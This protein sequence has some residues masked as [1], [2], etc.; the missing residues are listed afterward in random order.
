MVLA[1]ACSLSQLLHAPLQCRKMSANHPGRSDAFAK[2]AEDVQASS[3][4][5]RESLK[6][7]LNFKE[8]IVDEDAP[9]VSPVKQNMQYVDLYGVPCILLLCEKGRMGD[10]FPQTFSCLDLRIRTSENTSTLVQE[11]GRAAR[12]PAA[13]QDPKEVPYGEDL[14]M[15]KSA[16]LFSVGLNPSA[17]ILQWRFS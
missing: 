13:G 12:Y 14:E 2:W 3:E 11:M 16:L 15:L 8:Q 9:D 6:T 5:D 4:F 10:T 17:A 1:L 7:Y